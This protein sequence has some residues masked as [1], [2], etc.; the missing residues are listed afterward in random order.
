[1]A[2]DFPPVGFHFRVEFE[3]E[4]AREK[5]T[6]FQEVS[7][8]LAEVGTEEIPEGGENRCM[9]WN[10]NASKV[11][12]PPIVLECFAKSSRRSTG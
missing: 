4:D 11:R 10:T 9:M 12:A 5:D 6:R 8:L 1:M 3:L 2:A 7:G